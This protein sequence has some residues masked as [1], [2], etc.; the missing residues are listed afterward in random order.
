MTSTSRWHAALAWTGDGT[1]SQDVLIDVDGERI[2]AV[3]QGV[4][5]PPDSTP[6]RGLVM[7][8]LVNAHSHA[9]HRVL[10]G[11]GQD[12]GGDFWS[13]RDRMYAVAEILDPDLYRD[14]AAA[15]FAEMALAGITAV[16]EFHYLHHGPDG[17]PYAQPSAMGHALAD[18]A[19][20]AGIRL[21]LLDT[22]YLRS[23]FI[24][25]PLSAS[26]RRFTD[27]HASQWAERVGDLAS[28]MAGRPRV[29]VGAAIHS[30]RAVDQVGMS[31]VAEWARAAKAPL[32]FH[33]SEQPAENQAALAATGLTPTEL[34]EAAG[35]LGG[36]STAVHATHLGAGDIARLGTSRTSICLCP[37]TERD[38][39]DGIGPAMAL[40]SAGT[41]LVLGSD[42]HTQI[43]LFAEAR[44]VEHH[45]RLA[46][47]T[48][49]HHDPDDL[50]RAATSS[51]MRSLGWDAGR[52]ESGALADFI[53]I[54]LSSP[55]LA[56]SRPERLAAHV[57]F[58]ATAA[59]VS[60]VIVGGRAIVSDR[61]HVGLGDV[62]GL[63]GS[64]ID[65]LGSAVA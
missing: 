10:R 6:L 14:L 37:L 53:A 16:G 18:A 41:P 36:R 23:G 50:L 17:R 57:V 31:I 4:P 20:A 30:V 7:P 25:E 55:R 60:D 29:K 26:Q 46:S 21:T 62:A 43:D 9:F 34:L 52:L 1:V 39:A 22:C 15:V 61:H 27:G 58:A 35:A 47:R 64:A 8:G 44:A 24:G 28:A 5:Q 56:G 51:G 48:R 32:H 42:N 19:Q 49:G 33:L 12:A 65:S 3:T 11:H 45:E 38:L 59:D 13:W 63:L 40:A 54:D 2:V